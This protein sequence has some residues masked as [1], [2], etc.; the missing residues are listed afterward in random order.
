MEYKRLSTQYDQSLLDMAIG[1]LATQSN[2]S[3]VIAGVTSTAQ[4]K[5]TAA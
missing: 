3:S 5:Q 2:V 4:V 1:R